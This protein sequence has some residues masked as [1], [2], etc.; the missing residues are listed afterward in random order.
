MDDT[1]RRVEEIRNDIEETRGEMSETIDAIQDKLR[2]SH[3][4]AQATDRVKQATREGVREMTDSASE[5]ARDAMTHTSI[6]IAMIGIGTAWL[7]ARRTQQNNRTRSR[8]DSGYRSGWNRNTSRN[9]S[10]GTSE[11]GYYTQSDVGG[12]N[13]SANQLMANRGEY[14]G[15]SSYGSGSRGYGESGEYG[16]SVYGGSRSEFSYGGGM[17]RRSGGWQR[18][19]NQF[20]RMLNENPLLVGAGA[21][22]LGAAFGMAVPETDVENEWMGQARDS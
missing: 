13:E 14:S 22:M 9:W 3:I 1:S 6:P 18:Q 16:S 4:V 11:G 15:G 5:T 17:M 2:P 10:T 12:L 20:T 7:I 21:L 8:Y 19:Q